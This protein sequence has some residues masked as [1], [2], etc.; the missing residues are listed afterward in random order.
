MRSIM[1]QLNEYDDDNDDDVW[2]QEA[3]KAYKTWLLKFCTYVRP[4]QLITNDLCTVSTKLN[5]C[6]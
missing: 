5:F 2:H 6:T 3:S 1:L 4:R